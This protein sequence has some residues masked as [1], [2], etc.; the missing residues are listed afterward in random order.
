MGQHVANVE[1]LLHGQPSNP[2]AK[3][4]R[5][6][7]GDKGIDESPQIGD[8]S[9]RYLVELRANGDSQTFA[10]AFAQW[11]QGASSAAQSEQLAFIQAAWA[12]L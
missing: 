9:F 2:F 12:A 8:S 11:L 10:T 3:R 6:H 5:L 7:W 4:I 1:P